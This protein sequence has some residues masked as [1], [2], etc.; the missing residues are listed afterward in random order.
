MDLRD[1]QQISPHLRLAVKVATLTCMVLALGGCHRDPGPRPGSQSEQ[2]SGAKRATGTA[3]EHNLPPCPPADSPMLK[4]GSPG[5]GDHRVILSW[6]ASAPSANSQGERI[7]YCLYRSKKHPVKTRK[8]KKDAP[9]EE[10][11]QVNLTPM[12]E[13]ACVDDLVENDTTY[14]Y[15]AVAI[16]DEGQ[17][18]VLSSQARAVIP[19]SK[20]PLKSTSTRSY[21]PCR[22]PVSPKLTSGADKSEGSLRGIVPR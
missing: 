9:C 11:E 15:A 7:G 1:P 5:T 3:Q 10:C 17:L 12:L 18:S 4:R 6:N 2:T 14:Y 21:P 20:A 8:T 19:R 13:T 22:G 16:D